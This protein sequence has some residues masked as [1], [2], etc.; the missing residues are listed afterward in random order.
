M[1][2]AIIPIIMRKRNSVGIEA[3]VILAMYSPRTGRH[4]D[5]KDARSLILTAIMDDSTWRCQHGKFRAV[6]RACGAASD[7]DPP[8]P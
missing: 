8:S 4:Y 7:G 5:S 2:P 6:S 1:T 3:L